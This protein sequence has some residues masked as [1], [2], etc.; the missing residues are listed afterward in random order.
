MI[1]LKKILPNLNP[2][3]NKKNHSLNKNLVDSNSNK[4]KK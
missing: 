2:K 3:W 1:S 4:K